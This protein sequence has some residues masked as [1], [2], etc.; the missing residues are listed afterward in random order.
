MIVLFR[1][2]LL[3]GLLIA[4]SFLFAEESVFAQSNV[5]TVASEA[6]LRDAMAMGGLVVCSFDGTITLSN[7]IDVTRDVTLDAHGRSVVISGNNSN[8][9]FNVAS[10]VNFSVTN[11]VFANGRNVGANGADQGDIPGQPGSPGQGGAIFIDGGTV[12]LNSCMLTSNSVAGGRAGTNAYPYPV[13]DV[14]GDGQGGAIFVRGGSLMLNSVSAVSNSAS[15]GLGA[16]EPPLSANDPGTGGNGAGGALYATNSTVLVLNCNLSSNLCMAPAGGYPV[17]AASLGGALFLRSGFVTISNSTLLANMAVGGSPHIIAIEPATGYRPGRAYGGAVAA[18]SGT[19]T[20]VRCQV[21]SNAAIGGNAFRYSGTGEAQGGA[22]YSSG[23]VFASE[24]SFAGNQAL[25]GSGSNVNTDGRGGAFYNLGAAVVNACAFISNIARGGSAG[26]FGT[27]GVNYPG[28]NGW[29]GAIC[30]VSQLNITNCTIALNSAYGGDAGIPAGVPGGGLG[31][32]VFNSNG[33]FTAVN[34]TIASNSVWTGQWVYTNGFSDGANVAHTN[35]T[36]ALRNSILA[37]P[38]TNH[39]TWGTITDAGYNMS[40]D[41]SAN[42]NSGTS[43]NFTDPLLG[44]LADN[45]GPTLTMALSLNSPAVDFGTSIGAPQTDQRGFPRPA[46]LGFDM[47]AFELVASPIQRP[48]LTIGRA[49][50]SVWLSFQAQAGATYV[51]QNSTTLTNWTD[52]ETIGPFGSDTQ[53]S[54]TNNFYSPSI[55]FFRLRVQ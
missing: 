16:T 32:G 34:V 23:T 22:I 41:G 18:G 28:G 14:G 3:V 20:I 12:W 13:A 35:G 8:R 51:L 42:F 36:L 46:G 47:G 40:S 6:A 27:S 24:N 19:V 50:D 26:N 5:V 7:R 33:V 30:N 25:S 44:P 48:I 53:V 17:G 54:R 52:A 15:G 9:I 38:G 1:N 45:G 37:Y 21:I 29:G 11:V 4:F 39:N 49:G 2:Y 31:G 43:F 55:R 10:G